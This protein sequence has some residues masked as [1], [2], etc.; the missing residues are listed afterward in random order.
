MYSIEVES[1]K[2]AQEC[3]EMLLIPI[4]AISRRRPDPRRCYNNALKLRNST[5]TNRVR[6]TYHLSVEAD[7]VFYIFI[8]REDIDKTISTQIVC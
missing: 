4:E 6:R 1:E 3:P 2:H 7:Q 8:T 5:R